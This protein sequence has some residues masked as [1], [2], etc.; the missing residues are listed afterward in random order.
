MPDHFSSRRS[1]LVGLAVLCTCAMAGPAKAACELR[2]GWDEWP[3]YITRG[4]GQFRGLEFDLLKSAAESAGCKLDFQQ[5]PWARA[6]RMLDA[7]KLDLLYGAGYSAERAEFAKF[8][9]PYRLERFVLVTMSESGEETGS[10]SL[11]DWIRSAKA[12]GKPRVIGVFRGNVYG[13]QIDRIL[14]DNEKNVSLVKLGQNE[15]MIGMLEHGRLDGYI[16]ED[17]VAQMQM[18]MQ[19]SALPLQRNAIKEQPGDPLHYM[20]S[21][22]V[23]DDV[24]RRFND[25]IRKR[26]SPSQQ[27]SAPH[28]PGG[29]PNGTRV[30]DLGIVAG[31]RAGPV[32]VVRGGYER[33]RRYD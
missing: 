11:N 27:Q 26:K 7:R 8:S 22:D 13:E 17:G 25:A 23:S 14:K 33:R 30:V 12:G 5:V 3:P 15:Q 24:I 6:L 28:A 4:D 31:A 19:D 16:V 1:L 9:I 32:A 2:V 10:I 21:F 29:S 18:Q 20:F